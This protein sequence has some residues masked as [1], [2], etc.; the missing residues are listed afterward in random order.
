MLPF[1]GINRNV[2]REWRTLHRAFGGIG[3]LDL[4]VEHTICM[5]NIF[6]QHYGTGTTIALKFRACL[7]TLQLELGC[8]GNPLTEDYG[9]YSDLA[10]DSWVKSLWQR[11]HHFRFSLHIDYDTLPLPRRHDASLVAMFV[12]GGYSNE[13]L[14]ALNRCRISHKLIFLSDISTACGRFID[15][16]YILPPS[17]ESVRNRISSYIFPTCKPSRA[18]WALWREFWGSATGANGL[19]HIALGGW[20]HSS[21]SQWIWFHCA[22]TATHCS[23]DKGTRRRLTPNLSTGREFE[24]KRYIDT[25]DTQR[26]SLSTACRHT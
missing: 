12:R 23:S 19:L 16:E 22:Y 1:L 21:H 2:K 26:P 8:L 24:A 10:T 7:E 18:D 3:M 15:P 14:Q 5:I 4:A 11:L 25:Q 13:R 6:V 20:V 9:R 17:Q